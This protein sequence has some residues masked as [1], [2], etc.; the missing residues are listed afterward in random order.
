[1]QFSKVHYIIHFGHTPGD[2][3]YRKHISFIF[4]LWIVLRTSKHVRR[5]QGMNAC[6]E[7]FWST[8]LQEARDCCK[9]AVDWTEIRVCFLGPAYNMALQLKSLVDKRMPK[10]LVSSVNVN[11]NAMLWLQIKL[12][13]TMFTFTS[14]LTVSFTIRVELV[15]TKIRWR[16]LCMLSGK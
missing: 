10:H 14:M 16:V 1:M 7:W 11:I 3:V 15:G 4:A 13:W 6:F 12:F 5:T 2:K 8:N 9:A